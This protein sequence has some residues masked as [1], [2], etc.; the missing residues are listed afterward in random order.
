MRSSSVLAEHIV[1]LCLRERAR[2]LPE[3]AKADPK[4]GFGRA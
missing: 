1:A 3:Y 4:A 2:I